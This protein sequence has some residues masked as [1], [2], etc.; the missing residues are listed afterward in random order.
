MR[1]A[2]RARITRATLGAGATVAVAALVLTGCS[3]DPGA[4]GGGETFTF[5]VATIYGPENWQTQGIQG[6]TDAV[7]EASDGRITFEYFYQ[8]TLVAVPEFADALAS[9]VIDLAPVLGVYT[10][11]KFPIDNWLSTIAF[12]ADDG[13]PINVLQGSAATQEWALGEEGYITEYENNGLHVIVPATLPHPKYD[14]ICNKGPLETLDDFR[15]LNVR[16]SG[17]A[18]AGVAEA[19]GMIPVS[20]PPGEIF[21]G[22]Q[23]GVIDCMIGPVADFN[24]LGLLDIA[25]H[26]AWLGVVGFSAHTL[27][28]SDEKWNALP[29]D[30]QTVMTE[31]A[32][33]YVETFIAGKIAGEATA[34]L[35]LEELGLPFSVP[36]DAVF[37]VID[38]WQEAQLEAAVTTAPPLIDDPAGSVQRYLDLHDEWSTLLEEAGYEGYDSWTAWVEE[39]PSGEVDLSAWRQ[40][41]ADRI[42]SK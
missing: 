37:D 4:S 33:D 18:T 17:A 13:A 19:L 8:D 31:S 5:R 27:M 9:G 7:E 23:R 32:I 21:D 14:L 29:E 39:N 22:M 10:P 25:T 16:I 36:E 1:T 42:Y 38:A 41:L 2:R 30:L 12:A 6:Y 20:I 3:G 15:N 34:N 11:E 26:G 28:M 24:S 40:L 35:K